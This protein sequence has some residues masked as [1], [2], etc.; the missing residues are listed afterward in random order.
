M[1]RTAVVALAA[2]VLATTAIGWAVAAIADSEGE[3]PAADLSMDELG[4]RL[5][6]TLQ[7]DLR[8]AQRER[9][10]RGRAAVV[11]VDCVNETYPRFTCLAH[12]AATGES[13]RLVPVHPTI[14][15]RH[16]GG[17]GWVINTPWS[18]QP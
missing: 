16:G 13:R 4:Q 10:L 2:A 5:G 6:H 3:D 8:D 14:T 11:R 1:L 18:L 7:I 12:V 17:G 9:G 15:G